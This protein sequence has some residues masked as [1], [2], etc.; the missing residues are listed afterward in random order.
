M[1]RYPNDES[2]MKDENVPLVI[3]RRKRCNCCNCN[4]KDVCIMLSTF[5][6]I[7]LLIGGLTILNVYSIKKEDGSL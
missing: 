1:P 7:I 2:L 6:C 5:L 4:K 3:T